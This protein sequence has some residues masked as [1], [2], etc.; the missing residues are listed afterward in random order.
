MGKPIEIGRQRNTIEECCHDLAKWLSYYFI[1]L[2]FSYFFFFW[3]TQEK[4]AKKHH[5]T[6][7]YRV[8]IT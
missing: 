6:K 4:S 1:F 5:M 8:T 7:D 2:F 3:T